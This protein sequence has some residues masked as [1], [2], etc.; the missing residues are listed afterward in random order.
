[1]LHNENVI[2]HPFSHGEAVDGSASHS[3]EAALR[4]HAT[5]G[6]SFTNSHGS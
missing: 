2:R 4:P 3:A 5:F 6:A 1:V